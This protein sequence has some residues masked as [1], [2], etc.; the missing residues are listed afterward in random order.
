[1]GIVRFVG[2]W[3]VASVLLA[4]LVL[5]VGATAPIRDDAP[6][7]NTTLTGVCAFPVEFV[8]LANKEKLLTFFDRAGVPTRQIGTGA[9]K[10]RLT[11]L[12]T[13][14]TLVVNISGPVFIAPHADGS[15]TVELGGRSLLYLRQ[16]IDRPPA[17]ITLNA[18]RLV[19]A[20]DAAGAVTAIVSQSG[21]Q[22]DLCAELAGR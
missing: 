15:A 1:M 6:A 17:G 9:L 2:S 10:V 3:L 20:V 22:R 13:G 8:T 16:G 19:F 14:T 4:L 7:L 5:P 18:G 21:T 12:E 11:N